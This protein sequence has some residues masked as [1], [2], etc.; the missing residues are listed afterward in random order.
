MITPTGGPTPAHPGIDPPPAKS[1]GDGRIELPTSPTQTEN[2][3]TRPITHFSW[4]NMRLEGFEPPT[5][6]SGIQRA[7]IA[8]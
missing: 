1:G 4:E 2:H 5:F 8:P 3:A 6:G 7:A